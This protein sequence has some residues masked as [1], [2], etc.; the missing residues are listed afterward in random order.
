MLYVITKTKSWNSVKKKEF[1]ECSKKMSLRRA[2][3]RFKRL[4]WKMLFQKERL[5]LSKLHSLKSEN[6]MLLKRLL[7]PVDTIHWRESVL[8]RGCSHA[9][10]YAIIIK[11]LILISKLNG[12][13][14]SGLI[15]LISLQVFVKPRPGQF[16]SSKC[17]RTTELKGWL[18][19]VVLGQA[20]ETSK[21]TK[22]D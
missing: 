5:S 8:Q 2:K 14:I 7:Y 15:G 4:F 17:L 21:R 19:V 3:V 18:A 16:K 10:H 20:V 6:S 12:M 13:R 11:S 9:D 22:L 1:N